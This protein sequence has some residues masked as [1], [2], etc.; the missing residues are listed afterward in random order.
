MSVA[1]AL[2]L[3]LST[4][5]SVLAA[6]TSAN[7]LNEVR[8]QKQELQ[9]KVEKLDDQISQV[10][11]Q[12]SSNKKDIEK[13]NNSI[14]E[15]KENLKQAEEN[16]D[17]QQQLFNQRARAMYI[18]GVNSYLGVILNSSSLS[19]FLSRIDTVKRV[20]SSDK[21]VIND[22]RSKKEQ[23]AEQKE[24]LNNENN[25]LMA[26]KSD[27]EN[28]LVRLNSDKST[29]S[30]LIVE[31]DSKEKTL[32]SASANINNDGQ[33]VV[34]AAN[35][36]QKI[37]ELS[38]TISRGSSAAPASSNSIVAYASN[39]IGVPYVWG[40]TSP[41]GFDCSGLVQYVY[42]HF[43]ISLPR[44]SQAQQGVGTSV[45][46]Q[47]LQPGDLVFFGSPAYHVGIYVGNGSYINAPKTGDYVK[48]ASVDRPDFSGGRRIIK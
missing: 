36:V 16:I 11:N 39:F 5:G 1:I 29:Q 22:L 42:S 32:E 28:K 10:M 21:N 7:S 19:D 3:V 47:N 23:L 34:L 6:P 8:Q 35:N 24:Q 31:L 46:R 18:N 27:N 12:I 15:N 14:E 41:S 44:T 4:C 9:I 45:S 33:Q 26:L 48:I 30:K 13:I 43:G 38:P 25:K 37:R 40:G 20:M 2:A 17:A